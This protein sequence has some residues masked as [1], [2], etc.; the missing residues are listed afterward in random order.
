MGITAP[1]LAPDCCYC[2]NLPCIFSQRT[3]LT[4]I[5]ALYQTKYIL[6]I[7]YYGLHMTHAGCTNFA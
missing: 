6:T 7:A 3:L 2:K 4:S 5:N 1:N